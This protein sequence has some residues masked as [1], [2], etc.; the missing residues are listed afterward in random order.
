MIPT[1][2][3]VRRV[4]I[5]VACVAVALAAW[6][7]RAHTS[8]QPVIGTA[9]VGGVPATGGRIVAYPSGAGAN[10][11]PVTAAIGRGGAF[12]LAAPAGSYTVEVEAHLG[13]RSA[14]MTVALLVTE[15]GQLLLIDV[16]LT[17]GIGLT[18]EVGPGRFTGVNHKRPDAPPRE[19]S[20]RRGQG[21]R[22]AGPIPWPAPQ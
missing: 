13:V 4:M 20:S 16:P 18:R 17:R 9:R 11:P 5:A 15:G 14:R 21:T 22:D 1:R 8:R 2:F 7:Y 10:G 3:T 6:R 12:R 19:Q